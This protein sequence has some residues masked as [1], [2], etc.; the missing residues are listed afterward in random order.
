MRV[1]RLRFT[2]WGIT[3][4][5]V[6]V[7]TLGF[8][9]V[10]SFLLLSL[11]ILMFHVV[12]K[13]EGAE[14]WDGL[15]V[16]IPLTPWFLQDAVILPQARHRSGDAGMG[17]MVTFLFYSTGIMLVCEATALWRCIRGTTPMRWIAVAINWS[18][19]C[20]WFGQR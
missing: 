16:G 9:W 13:N 2:R 1:S 15:L 20:Q 10:P 4:A 3:A 17:V 18:W 7:S 19:L 6:A 11:S 12:T 14:Y 5:L 8:P